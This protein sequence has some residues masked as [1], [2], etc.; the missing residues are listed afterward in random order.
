MRSGNPQVVTM[1]GVL[2]SANPALR[3]R[4]LVRSLGFGT[5]VCLPL[6]ARDRVLGAMTFVRSASGIYPVEDIR[7]AAELAAR[8]AMALDNG[9]L[10]R[11]ARRRSL[12]RRFHLHRFPRAEHP[13]G[14]LA[15]AD[16]RAGT[17]GP[18]P[19]AR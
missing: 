9:D 7:F 17:H 16:R 4:E 18:P 3:T 8:V 10:Y 11:R 2:P 19:S 14:R 12:S 13:A 15:A 1:D 6:R 5:A